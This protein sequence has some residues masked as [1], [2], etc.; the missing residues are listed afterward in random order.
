MT[1]VAPTDRPK[2]VHNRC[3]IEVFGGV[4]GVFGVFG[5]MLLFL[6][7]CGCRGFCHM[8]ESDLFFFVLYRRYLFRTVINGMCTMQL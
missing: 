6:F 3:V 5:V 4:F 1:V 2:L 7:S 8:T